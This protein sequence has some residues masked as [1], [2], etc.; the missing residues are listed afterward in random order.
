MQKKA[1]RCSPSRSIFL[2]LRDTVSAWLDD[3]APSMGAA[4][5]YYTVFSVAPLLLIVIT[6]AGVAFGAEAA[7]GA[8]VQRIGG[9]VGPEGAAAIE[10]MLVSVNRPG[11]TRVTAVIGVAALFIG[12][13]TVFAELQDALDRIWRAPERKKASGIV[14]FF[15]TRVLSFGMVLGIGFLL[16]VSLVA[17]AALSALG[18]AWLPLSEI[19]ALA[20]GADTLLSFSLVTVAFALIYKTIPHANVRWPDVWLGALVTSAL[21]TFGK[22]LIG[23]Y[24]GKAGVASGYGAAGSLVVV[25][26]WVYYSAQIFLLGAEF[27]WLYANRYGSRKGLPKPTI[28]NN[29]VL[30]PRRPARECETEARERRPR[31]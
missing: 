15:R 13:T 18:R 19:E 8:V 3:Y 5:A 30:V 11:A 20:H 26:I 14:E 9:L 6:V 25:L 27:T 12:A 7:R 24:I 21:F 4:L 31:Q 1:D 29:D 16:I 2:L 22:L 17:S 10:A 23:L 28:K